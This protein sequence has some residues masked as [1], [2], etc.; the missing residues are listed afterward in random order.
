AAEGGKR[1][2]VRT[3]RVHLRSLRSAPAGN[4]KG[5]S[6]PAYPPQ[7]R[8][9]SSKWGKLNHLVNVKLDP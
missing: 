1:G 4:S 9:Y 5:V 6:Y 2:S 3:C 8:A 7:R